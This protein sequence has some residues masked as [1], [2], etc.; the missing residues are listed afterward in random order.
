MFE[1]FESLSD[2][3]MELV[4]GIADIVDTEWGKCGKDK[5]TIDNTI[6]LCV[7]LFV[8]LLVCL[9]R[10]VCFVSSQVQLFRPI[11]VQILQPT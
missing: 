4:L 1:L 3:P 7:R 8:L 6:R 5:D 11:I 10:F 2:D 9:S